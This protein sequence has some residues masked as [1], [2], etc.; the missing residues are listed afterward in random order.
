MGTPLE[1]LPVPPSTW[2]DVFAEVGS[3]KARQS[4][5]KKWELRRH[6]P[7]TTPLQPC[8]TSREALPV[9]PCPRVPS[10]RLLQALCMQ[11]G[12]RPPPTAAS[13]RLPAPRCA[14]SESL[15]VCPIQSPHAGG[16]PS[17]TFTRCRGAMPSAGP[18]GRCPGCSA[19][20]RARVPAAAR[21]CSRSGGK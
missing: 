10:L 13:G 16:T 17:G 9:H 18:R 7:E 12:Q 21:G 6:T 1:F 11:T 14:L 20:V 4:K 19:G 2:P 5:P 8:T 3:T 15:G